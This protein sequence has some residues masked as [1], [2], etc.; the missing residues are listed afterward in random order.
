V[1]NNRQPGLQQPNQRSKKVATV[2][3]ALIPVALPTLLLTS[4]VILALEATT[5][6][7]EAAA[8]S[9]GTMMG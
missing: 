4:S 7:G 8:S 1:Q 3:K 5:G 2:N 6:G 9:G